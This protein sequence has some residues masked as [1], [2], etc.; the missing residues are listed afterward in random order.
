VLAIVPVKKSFLGKI[1]VLTDSKTSKV[2]EAV[3]S[4]LKSEKLA[5]I[6]GQKTS[7]STSLT[8]SLMISDEFSLL[9]PVADFYDPNGKNFTKTG[10]DP[11]IPMLPDNAINYILKTR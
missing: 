1:Y 7:G 2:F 3:A 4:I 9:L 6:V 5:T 11:D 10:I 8:E